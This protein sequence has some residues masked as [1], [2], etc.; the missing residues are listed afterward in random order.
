MDRDPRIESPAYMT[1]HCYARPVE[2]KQKS[3]EF[4]SPF[5]ND[6]GY[7]RYLLQLETV[8]YFIFYKFGPPIVGS[9]FFRSPSMIY[10][11]QQQRVNITQILSDGA[12]T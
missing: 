8:F 2:E 1:D 7:S 9:L 4:V 12:T 5:A 10:I 11:F 3:N 6:H